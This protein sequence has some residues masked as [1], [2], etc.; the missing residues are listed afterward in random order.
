VSIAG[1]RRGRRGAGPEA[2]PV[3]ALDLKKL[4]AADYAVAGGTLLYLVLAVLP[5]VDFGDYVDAGVP[6]DSISGFAFSGMVSI[7]FLLFLVATVWPLLPAVT[8]VELGFPRGWIAVGLAALGLL[9]T[10]VTWIRSLTYGFEVWPLL[11]VLVAAAIA[12]FALL[13]LLPE[14]RNRPG[15]PGGPERDGLR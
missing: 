2:E 1:R 7:S 9:L 14:L 6:V 3:I 12:V 13:S 4:K 8:G 10:F 15:L 5:W 11:A